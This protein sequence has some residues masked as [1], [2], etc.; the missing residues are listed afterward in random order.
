MTLTVE[1][2]VAPAIPAV[3]TVPE[4]LRHAAL[5]I[6]ERGHNVGGYLGEDGS[7][8]AWGAIN[9][10]TFGRAIIPFTSAE[11]PAL[12]ALVKMVGFDVG[13]W[14]DGATAEQVATTLRAA[15]D[16]SEAGR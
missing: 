7:V 15:A 5:I 9:V 8:C 3:K 13:G 12:D 2:P 10:A 1:R 6:E 11:P 14:S 4:V 16:A